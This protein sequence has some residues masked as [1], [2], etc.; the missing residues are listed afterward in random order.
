MATLAVLAKADDK[1][2]RAVLGLLNKTYGPA[3]KFVLAGTGP[4]W[5][6]DVMADGKRV[7][8]AGLA[9]VQL[10]MERLV[11][12]DGSVIV[13][14][15]AINEMRAFA[16]KEAVGAFFYLIDKDG[17]RV[18]EHQCADSLDNGLT[19][20]KENVIFAWS[21]FTLLNGSYAD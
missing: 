7:V 2:Q 13:P 8:V 12:E 15:K 19:A 20:S 16:E 9:K 18:W 1:L 14:V 4:A 3:W 10:T 5:T 17:G 21:R 6:F 11:D